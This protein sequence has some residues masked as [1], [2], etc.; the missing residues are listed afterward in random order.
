V[1]RGEGMGLGKGEESRRGR[2]R[3]AKVKA[4]KKGR[5]ERG[6]A[7]FFFTVGL[8]LSLSLFDLGTFYLSILGSRF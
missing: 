6:S 8:L 5:E 3:R 4:K 7:K 1:S 2:I